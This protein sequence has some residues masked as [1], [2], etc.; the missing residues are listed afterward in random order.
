MR[1]LWTADN[2]YTLTE[3]AKVNVYRLCATVKRIANF[4]NNFVVFFSPF[5]K[6]EAEH[7]WKLSM[8]RALEDA[9]FR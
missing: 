8:L 1:I 4:L 3:S 6:L 2:Y 7:V 9:A 5:L